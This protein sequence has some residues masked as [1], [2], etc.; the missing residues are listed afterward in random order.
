MLGTDPTEDV[1]VPPMTGLAASS[2]HPFRRGPR[3]AI[4]QAVEGKQP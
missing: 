3:V 1:A 2:G 4:H